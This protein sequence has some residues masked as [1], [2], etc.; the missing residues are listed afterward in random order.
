MISGSVINLL[1]GLVIGAGILAGI[2]FAISIAR[3]TFK[4]QQAK[5]WFNANFR[6][7][8]RG[9]FYHDVGKRPW[10]TFVRNTDSHVVAVGYLSTVKHLRHTVGYSLAASFEEI[11][12]AKVKYIVLRMIVD[13]T[14]KFLP[15]NK[16]ELKAITFDMSKAYCL[17]FSTSELAEIEPG[18]K[19][20]F[21]IDS[22]YMAV[23][24]RCE[25]VH[26]KNF[27]D[28]ETLDFLTE[29]LKMAIEPAVNLPPR[30]LYNG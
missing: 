24:K 4:E 29:A 30:G 2:Y 3:R 7:V 28:V 19:R 17:E 18:E 6:G 1:L 14:A 12:D 22:E 21:K 5:E 13:Q 23:H 20:L 27:I 10:A 9:A 15:L 26:G 11:K 8:I 25:M 16:R